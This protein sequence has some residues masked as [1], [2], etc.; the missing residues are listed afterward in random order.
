M[1]WEAVGGRLGVA[2]CVAMGLGLG[3][4]AWRVNATQATPAEPQ[5]PLLSQPAPTRALPATEAMQQSLAQ[6]CQQRLGLRE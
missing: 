4:L 6:H 5:R 2:V 3:A 1:Q